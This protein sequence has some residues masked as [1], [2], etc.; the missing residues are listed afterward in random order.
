MRT[1]RKKR[2]DL[3]N[4]PRLNKGTNSRT[5]FDSLDYD[6]LEKLSSE[7]LAWL[8][9]FSGEY[10]NAAFA[11]EEGSV[12]GDGRYK[13]DNLHTTDALRKDCQYRN[14]HNNVDY[15]SVGKAKGE[16][17]YPDNL[18]DTIDE[19]T[20]TEVNVFEQLMEVVLDGKKNKA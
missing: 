10:Y 7:E 16:A 3:K 18:V 20:Y 4:Y 15:I 17:I 5:K 2:V 9:K 13:R 12:R 1:K 8:N 19:A 14:N 6:Y 11:K